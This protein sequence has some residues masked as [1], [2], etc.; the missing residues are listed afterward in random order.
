P[1]PSIRLSAPIH[2]TVID[3]G[4]IL[5]EHQFAG[6]PLVPLAV[7][8]PEKIQA[9]QYD[10]D[11][12]IPVRKLFR[13][14]AQLRVLH[15]AAARFTGSSRR[16]LHRSVFTKPADLEVRTLGIRFKIHQRVPRSL[17]LLWSQWLNQPAAEQL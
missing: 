5:L 17:D 15:P 10:S 14:R 6:Q 13:T 4:Q 7:E 11:V 1:R 9:G 12:E 8:E 3:L 16:R 2:P